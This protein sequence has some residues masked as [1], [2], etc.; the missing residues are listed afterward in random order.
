[1]RDDYETLEME[2]AGFKKK[3]EPDYQ[4]TLWEA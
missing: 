2:C 4:P 1:M 3:K